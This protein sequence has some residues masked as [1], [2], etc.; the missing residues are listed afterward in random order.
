V[1]G[2]LDYYGDFRIGSPFG[3]VGG[4]N[5]DLG[6]ATT[7]NAID[8][9]ELYAV[10]LAP[11]LVDQIMLDGRPVPLT[12]IL[13]TVEYRNGDGISSET[14]ESWTSPIGPVV[15]RAKGQAFILRSAGEGEHRGG[16]QFLRMMRARS[17]AEW[18][19][20]LKLRARASSNF[21]YADR[22]G[23]IFYVWNGA[24]P[25]LPH[26]PGGDSTIVPV[27]STRD[28]WSAIVPFDS[29][30]QVKNPP[31]G[32][33]H[34]ENSSPHFTNLKAVLD[35]RRLPANVEAPSLSLRSQLAL[36]LIGKPSQKLSLEDVLRLKHSYR[37]LLADRVKGELLEAARAVSSDRIRAAVSVLES[38]DN[39]AAAESRG[40]VLFELWWRLY[41]ARLPQPFEEPWSVSQPTTTP[42]GIADR[43]AAVETL[44]LAA[45]S[46]R[47]RFG[48]L[49]VPWGEVHRVRVG[50][51]DL[52]VGGCPGGLGCFRVLWFRDEPDGKRAVQG[53][54]GWVLAVEFGTVPR[55]YS[56]LAY[57]ESNQP[58]SPWHADQ[59]A[60]FA[61][62]ELKPVAFT[63]ADVERS[64]V[65]RY[66]P[67]DRKDP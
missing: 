41:S 20:A 59:A 55:A 51:A 61:R 6:W 21:T 28:V 17:F 12:R 13:T 42:R 56:V 43:D 31:D 5:Q 45:D 16:E 25:A 62:G 18:E 46:V 32:Y 34:N 63:R 50:T 29:M 65:R 15:E 40:A 66:R 44:G 8:T 22:A 64:A 24:L 60:R 14:R 30:P 11:G 7:N 36:E 49:D 57:G 33:V 48:R 38:W 52:P 53:G 2:A 3:V 26:P 58:G 10:D 54:D 37:M 4:F 19:S 39:T 1:P 47:T 9:D 23:N 35:P 27:R 67:G